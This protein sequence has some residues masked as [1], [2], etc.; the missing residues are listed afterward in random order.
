MMTQL[1]ET[2]SAVAS[3]RAMA[4][5]RDLTW[6]LVRVV[7]RGEVRVGGKDREEEEEWKRRG[8]GRRRGEGV[9]R[10]EGEGRRERYVRIQHS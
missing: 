3:G 5:M 1:E 7:K 4:V 6:E 9:D 10:R 8:E 2:M